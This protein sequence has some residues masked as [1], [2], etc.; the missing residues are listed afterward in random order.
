MSYAQGTSVA[1]DRSRGELERILA[2]YGATGFA[3]G[4]DG[5]THVLTFRAHGRIIRFALTVP[6]MAD[7]VFTPTGQRRHS[8]EKVRSAHEQEVRRRWLVLVVK[9]KLEAV[10]TGITSFEDEFLA[11]MVLPNG[12]TVGDFMG[13]QLVDVYEHGQ[14]PALLPGTR[15]ELTDGGG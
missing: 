15:A 12:T 6:P 13:P 3:Y 1:V 5:D 4:W 11:H 8:Q 10:T 9:A 2:R 7:F 14:M